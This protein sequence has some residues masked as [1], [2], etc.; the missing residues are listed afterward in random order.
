MMLSSASWSTECVCVCVLALTQAL[1]LLHQLS[2]SLNEQT[3]QRPLGG[4][5]RFGRHS[6]THE[7]ASV[8]KRRAASKTLESLHAEFLP[9]LSKVKVVPPVFNLPDRLVNF[10]SLLLFSFCNLTCKKNG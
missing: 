6:A 4:F 5:V 1:G 9:F 7:E 8:E 3:V 2:R 10:M